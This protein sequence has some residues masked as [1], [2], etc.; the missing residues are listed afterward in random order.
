MADGERKDIEFC[1]SSLKDLRDF[2]DSAMSEAGYQLDRVQA[3]EEPD[4]WKPMQSVGAGVKEI[5]VFVSEGT[6]RVLY[7]A[8]FEAAVYVLHCFEKKSEK[9]KKSDIELARKRYELL[10]MELQNAK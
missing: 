6:Y 1:G 3:G 10:L 2:P 7:V 9:T 5:R 4:D 8:K